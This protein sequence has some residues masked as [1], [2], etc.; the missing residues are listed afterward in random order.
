ML[1]LISPTKTLNFVQ[2]ISGLAETKPLFFDKSASLVNVIAGMSLA[3]IKTIFKLSDMLSQKTFN[4]YQDWSVTDIQNPAIYSYAGTVFDKMNPSQ[5]SL[6]DMQFAQLHLCIIDGLYGLLRPMDMIKRYRLE[7]NTKIPLHG[8]K[9]LYAFWCDLI[10]SYLQTQLCQ[11]DYIINLASK[12]YFKAI[13]FED[14]NVLV[15]TPTFAEWSNGVLKTKATYAK[16]ARGLMVA[17]CIK[18]QIE[19]PNDLKLFNQEGYEFSETHSNKNN[20]VFIRK[21]Q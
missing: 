13:K 10:T 15:I 21:S 3:Q 7:M 20:F 6:E 17:F 1:I 5:F 14:L 8:F 19:N 2:N 11:S 12:E 16:Q 18:N 4:E 9:N